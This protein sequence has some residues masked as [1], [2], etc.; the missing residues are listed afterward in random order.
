VTRV[1][2]PENGIVGLVAANP[3]PFTLTGTNTWIVGRDPAWLVDPGPALD[4]HITAV[5]GEIERRGGLA[6]IALTHDHHD[7]SEGVAPLRRRFPDASLAAAR[8]NVD[9]VLADGD[10]FGPFEAVATPGHAPDHLTFLA[11]TVGLTGDA[12]LG[13]GS[14]F[15]AP[16]PGALAGYLAGLEG[17]RGRE[18]SILL[19]GHG[20]VVRDPAAK[21]EEYIDHRLARERRLV[22]A[23]DG[24]A[25]SVDEMLDA[26]WSDVPE[27]LRPAAAVTL[28]AHLDKLQDEGRLPAGVERPT[29]GVLLEPSGRRS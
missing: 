1:E 7:H 14:V 25:R 26:A 11:G 5:A 8:G 22:E 16:D 4:E 29:A 17:L 23:L 10:R 3:G 24:G 2:L 12:V 18:L 15:I 6:G 27:L 28:A 13:Y 9:V 19:P 21:L 20:P